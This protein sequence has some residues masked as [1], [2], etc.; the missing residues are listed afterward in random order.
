MP[1]MFPSGGM[2]GIKLVGEAHATFPFFKREGNP[3]LMNFPTSE[4]GRTIARNIPIGHRS[5]VYL[6]AP[7]RRL[8][9]AIEYIKWDSH[10]ADVLEEGSRAA[11]AQ[12]ATAIREV[13]NSHYAKIWRCIRV[14]A[15]IDDYMNGP[16]QDFEFHEGDIMFDMPEQEYLERFDA[17][18][19]S[20]RSDECSGP[21]SG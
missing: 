10:S 11:V 5:L 12:G 2:F 14:L 16:V 6:M 4:K 7:A 13:F 21:G 18:P 17:I 19:W 3:A 1:L 20:W 9:T 8:W 15:I